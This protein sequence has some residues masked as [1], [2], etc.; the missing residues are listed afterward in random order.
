MNTSYRT[1]LSVPAG[2]PSVSGKRLGRHCSAG[3]VASAT[4][5]LLKR[6]VSGSIHLPHAA[7]ADLG[8]DGVGTERGAR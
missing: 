2:A 6:G 8:G 1:C 7:F 4:L 3:W 5:P